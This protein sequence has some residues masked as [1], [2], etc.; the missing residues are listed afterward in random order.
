M[1]SNIGGLLKPLPLPKSSPIF[2]LIFLL[3]VQF[4]SYIWALNK[5]PQPTR[6]WTGHTAYTAPVA[7][8]L[9]HKEASMITDEEV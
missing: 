2:L 6:V 1:R 8:G 7:E 4:S 9:L 3:L 5:M